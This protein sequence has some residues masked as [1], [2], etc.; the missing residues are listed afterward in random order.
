MYVCIVSLSSAKRILTCVLIFVC[1]LCSFFSPNSYQR[2]STGW[3]L[4]YFYQTGQR[5]PVSTWGWRL[6]KNSHFLSGAGSI[7]QVDLSLRVVRDHYQVILTVAS[8][9]GPDTLN[10]NE[11]SS[12]DSGKVRSIKFSIKRGEM[13]IC[14]HDGGH[15]SI[16]T[17]QN[18]LDLHIVLISTLT[19]NELVTTGH[20]MD[21]V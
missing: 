2:E 20:I 9:F 12:H 11:L 19:L 1:W 18:W 7:N 13:E 21:R 16:P 4:V 14:L 8:C 6:P 17:W 15:K 3:R 10:I 5:W